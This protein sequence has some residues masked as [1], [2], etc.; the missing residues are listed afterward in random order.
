[1]IDFPFSYLPWW[2]NYLA[3]WT[4]YG[5]WVALLFVLFFF[6]GSQRDDEVWDRLIK[7]ADQKVE[8]H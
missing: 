3:A 7:E 6:G 5:C 8:R 1:M 2:L 4:G